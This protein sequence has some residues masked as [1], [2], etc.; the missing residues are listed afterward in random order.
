VIERRETK[1]EDPVPAVTWELL[2]PKGLRVDPGR[3]EAFVANVMAYR[4]TDFWG[5]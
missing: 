1:K 5:A 4:I 3:V 2:E